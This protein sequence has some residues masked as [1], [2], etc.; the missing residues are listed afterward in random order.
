MNCL[1]G[2]EYETW[3]G[4]CEMYFS[5]KRGSLKSFLQ[6]FPF[7]KLTDEEKEVLKSENFYKKYIKTGLIIFFPSVMQQLENFI[8]KSDGSF[9]D[10]S[11]VS[12]LTY[13]LVQ[14]VGKEISR[15]YYSDR[16]A[17]ISVYYAGNYEYMRPNYKQDYD[18]FFKELNACAENYQYFIKTD[19][20]NFYSN[21]NIDKLI[22]QIDKVC[23]FEKVTFS[24][25]QLYVWKELLYFCGDGKFPLIENSIA[26]SFLS[27]IVYLD[28]VDSELYQYIQKNIPIFDDFRMVRYVD[29]MY[30]LVSSDKPIEYLHDAYNE[31]RNEYSSILRKYGLALNTQKSCFRPMKEINQELKK[32]LY[33]EYVN[34]DKCQIEE[35]FSG[36]LPKFLNELLVKLL[37]ENMDIESYN[38]LIEKHFSSEDIEFTSSEVLNYFI[39]ENETE[40]K[41]K[42]VTNEIINLIKQDISF[43]N[44]DPK[45]LTIMIMKTNNQDA[46]NTFLNQL[47]N[48][49]K[50]EKWNLFDTTIAINYLIQSQF[51]HKDLID[52]IH[53]RHPALYWFYSY[54]CKRSFVENLDKKDTNKLCEVAMNDNKVPYLYFMFLCEIKRKNYM[55]G[56]AYFKNYFDRISADLDW[57]YTKNSSKKNPNYKKFYTEKALNSLYKNIDDS[58]IVIKKAHKLRNANPLSHASAE[59]LDKESTT[60]DLIESIKELR[61]LICEYINF[62]EKR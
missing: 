1:F 4:T 47:F 31:I 35:L 51:K 40:L 24:Q 43:I 13:L 57:F 61:G 11:L 17:D 18:D 34:G 56:F 15:C 29:D 39:Y 49:D 36:T 46:I 12:P 27:T 16:P 33:D 62:I 52:I 38:M 59:L 9:R 41:T 26:S 10:S 8:Q 37:L 50:N 25:V 53:K 44:F 45:R 60:A 54:N 20:T 22:A 2:I 21:I 58:K 55:V 3:K 19:I 30:I 28:K 5:L 42:E 7:T 14:A 23:N 32:S 48:R 6:W